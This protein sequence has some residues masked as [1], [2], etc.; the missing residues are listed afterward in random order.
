MFLSTLSSSTGA[1]RDKPGRH[2]RT[3]GEDPI[4]PSWS[5]LTSFSS[6]CAW[7]RCHNISCM[8]SSDGICG[9]YDSDTWK[10]IWRPFIFTWVQLF[11]FLASKEKRNILLLVW[12][13]LENKISVVWCM[14]QVKSTYSFQLNGDDQDRVCSTARSLKCYAKWNVK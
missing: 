13:T 2:C 1:C 5:P 9:W 8:A 11:F 6:A 3:G 14:I 12:W 4:G 10:Y 7:P